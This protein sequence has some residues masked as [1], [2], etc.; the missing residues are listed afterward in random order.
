MSIYT[1]F[2]V[3]AVPNVV[4]K[5]KPLSGQGVENLRSTTPQS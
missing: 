5:G 3:V 1:N 2:E 4:L